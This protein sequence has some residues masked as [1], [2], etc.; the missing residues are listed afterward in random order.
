MSDIDLLR[1]KVV[2][3]RLEKQYAIQHAYET[4]IADLREFN[5][6]TISHM[7]SGM[8]SPAS[9][10]SI[11]CQFLEEIRDMAID[12]I[13]TDH[14]RMPGEIVNRDMERLWSEYDPD[15]QIPVYTGEVWELFVELDM[16]V[17]GF[18]TEVSGLTTENAQYVIGRV[19]RD[20]L[21]ALLRHAVETYESAYEDMDI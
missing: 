8:C 7:I 2:E 20:V 14:N 17:S 13:E 6:H 11:G 5:G 21:E 10:E 3:M 9:P 19:A 15:N 16:F 4:T 18:A 1:E 12:A